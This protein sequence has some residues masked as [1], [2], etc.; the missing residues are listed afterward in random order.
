MITTAERPAES[1]ERSIED[2]WLQLTNA[3]GRRNVYLGRSGALCVTHREDRESPIRQ[4][5]GCF[6]RAIGLQDF[7]A[8]VY[9][10]WEGMRR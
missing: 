7:R 10:V 2:A 4:H 3:S 9:H 1:L 6:T 8:E 5:V